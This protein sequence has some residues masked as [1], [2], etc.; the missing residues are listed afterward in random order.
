VSAIVSVPVVTE[1]NRAWLVRRGTLAEVG[2]MRL[3]CRD[4]PGTAPMIVV[5]VLGCNDDWAAYVHQAHF[6][7]QYTAECGVKLYSQEAVRLF[8]VLNPEAYR[9]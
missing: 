7:V 2:L 8:P 6:G 1:R 3:E 9:R 5:A 4:V